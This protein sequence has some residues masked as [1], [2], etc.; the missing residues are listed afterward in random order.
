MTYV[1]TYLSNVM[2]GSSSVT[3]GGSPFAGKVNLEAFCLLQGGF[4][5]IESSK[6]QKQRLVKSQ[7]ELGEV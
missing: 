5:Y 2:S 1:K 3:T 6:K 4:A 7:K